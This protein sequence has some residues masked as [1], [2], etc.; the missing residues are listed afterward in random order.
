MSHKLVPGQQQKAG[1]RVGENVCEGGT[2]TAKER[3]TERAERMCVR[4]EQRQRK[5]E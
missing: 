3:G 2:E 1:G 5:S 4:E